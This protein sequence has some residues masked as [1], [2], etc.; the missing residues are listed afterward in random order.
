MKKSLVTTLLLGLTAFVQAQITDMG[1]PY[2]WNSTIQS[3]NIPTITMGGFDQSTIDNEDAIN[4]QTKDAP[5][6]FGYKYDT[7]ITLDNS[8]IWTNLFNG[9]RTWQTIIEC[10][11]AMTINL[12]LEDLYLPEG[13]YLYLY[14]VDQTNRVG[15]YTSRNNRTDGLLGTELVHGDKIIVEYYE[16]AE[17]NGLGSLTISNVIHG[18]RSLTRIQQDLT[19]ALND[20]YACNIDV[21]CPLGNGW[22]E[23]IRSVA[24][25]VVNGNGICSGAL[26]NNTCDD[27]TPYFLTANHCLGGGTGNWAFRFN[28]ESPPGTESCA[29]TANSTNPGPPYD[30]TANGATILANG[31]V[32]DFALL[33][34]DNMTLTDAQNWNCFYAGWDNSDATTVTQATGI[35]HPSGD[36]KKICRE[37]NAPYHATASGAQVWWIDA[38]E[39]GVTEPGS[40]GSPLFDQNQRIIGQ[41]YGGL[42]ACTSPNG[43][44]NNG[45]YDYYGR[46]GVS[47]VNGVSSYLA[48]GSC[49]TA[50]TNDGYDPNA[51]TCTG[52][53][54]SST[55]EETCFGDDDGSITVTVTGGAGPFTYTLSGNS[56]STGT[57]NN[58]AQGTY[59]VQV[60]DNNSCISTI[61]VTLGGP[62]ALSTGYSKTHVSCNGGSD[63]AL[64][65]NVT[66]GTAPYTYNIGSGSQSGNT[67]TGLTAGTYSITITDDNNCTYMTSTNLNEPNV[68][69]ASGTSSP[70]SGGSDGSINLSTS[71]GTAPMSYSWT[72]PNGFTST[73]EDPSGLE[74]G[75]YTVVVTD[76]KGCTYSIDVTVDYGV[77]FGEDQIDFSVF[78]NPSEGIYQVQ[79]STIENQ[80]YYSIL[81]VTGRIIIKE[82]AITN[83]KFFVDL[84]NKSA[85]TYYMIISNQDD[86]IITTLIKK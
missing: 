12:L 53:L 73:S 86:R 35:H 8:G 13:S 25:I 17:V 57:F 18:Y 16:P 51:P 54:S 32:A 85:G 82:T 55:T 81:D 19:K 33:E 58:L 42:A 22:E 4:D 30:Q 83:E 50:T 23:Q 27:G 26:I 1:G 71:G 21:N 78:P 68:L 61:N 52:T 70:D 40:S 64:T 60:E 67:F 46:F 14:D 29:T 37:S 41:L 84:S 7:D 28:W 49:G 56:Q 62:A 38:W 76:A 69:T 5:W 39:Q 63:G 43:T 15:A 72:G 79:I 6:R 34:I 2:S 80:S 45:D 75:T 74:A 65:L 10:P 36:L 47:W 24:M 3:I 77:G 66:G 59:S 9:D 11:G 31:S 44:S 48:P 20:S